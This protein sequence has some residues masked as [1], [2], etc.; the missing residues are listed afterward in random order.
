MDPSKVT[1]FANLSSL[2]TAEKPS[3]MVSM[4]REQLVFC[5]PLFFPSVHMSKGK[6]PPPKSPNMSP[7]LKG[8]F[9][10][11]RR[12]VRMTGEKVS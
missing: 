11:R 12:I 5:G 10:R 9:L 6:F 3:F 2:M 4:A 1:F 7:D 8:H